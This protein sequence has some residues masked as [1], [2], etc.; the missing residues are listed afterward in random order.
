MDA[1]KQSAAALSSGAASML[2]SKASAAGMIAEEGGIAS[3]MFGAV[4]EALGS[5]QI[6]I[7]LHVDGIK[8]GEASIRGINRATRAAGRVLLEI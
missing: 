7:P 6:V 4:N 1:A 8:L 3:M 2:G 5:T